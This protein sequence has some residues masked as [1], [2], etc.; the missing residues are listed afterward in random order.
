MRRAR[1]GPGQLLSIDPD[2]G[3]LFDGELKRELAAAQ[4]VRGVG[5]R[6]AS[7]FH[8]R[9]ASRSRRPRATSASRHVL[10]GYTREELTLM[11]RPIA[12]TGQDP[13]YSMGDDAPIAPL[14]GRA[15]PLAS[16]FRQRFAQVT[17]PAIDHYRERTVMSVAT[18]VGPRAPLDAEGAAAAARSSCRRSSLTP[19]GLA[20][21]EPDEVDA[22]FTAEE[23]LGA[24][25]ERVADRASRLAEAGSTR[26]LSHR[27]GG[28]RRPAPDPVA[29]RRRGGARPARRARACARRARSSS[30]R[31]EP[32]DT[33]MVATLVGYGADV[34]LPAARARD[35]R[36]ARRRRQDRRRPADARRG[37]GR[38]LC[39]RSRTAC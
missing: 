13:V 35:G 6:R 9:R 16:Y 37:A 19:D 1:L 31:D 20:A 27:R 5:R 15:R 7:R 30:R 3:L 39:A 22:T 24:A 38:L 17:N 21:L 34:D 10:H 18:L 2:R 14:A 36:A 12:Q 32:R 11:L 29:P 23:G 8:G 4:A 26:A 33:H 28:G 25:V